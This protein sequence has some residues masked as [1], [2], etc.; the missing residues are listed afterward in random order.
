MKKSKSLGSKTIASRL[1]RE[2][3]RFVKEQHL[4][5]AELCII[6]SGNTAMAMVQ[7]ADGNYKRFRYVNGAVV[8]ES[9]VGD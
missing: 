9:M 4:R 1:G 3:K 5:I 6:D 8:D 7:F 2:V